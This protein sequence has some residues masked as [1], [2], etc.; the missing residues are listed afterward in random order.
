MRGTQRDLPVVYRRD[1]G[2][3]NVWK[4]FEADWVMDRSQEEVGSR[5][6]MGFAR[7]TTLL[8]SDC[9]SVF[10]I[11][12]R[13]TQQRTGLWWPWTGKKNSDVAFVSDFSYSVKYRL[14]MAEMIS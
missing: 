2:Q 11:S 7:C 4:H 14:C 12:V 1:E 13:N 10:L 3:A 5:G 8:P 6:V 9:V